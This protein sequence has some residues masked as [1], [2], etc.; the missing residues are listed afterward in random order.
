MLALIFSGVVFLILIVII[1]QRKQYRKIIKAKEYDIVYHIREQNKLAK[2]L[3]YI[4]VEKKVMEKI[5][6]SKIDVLI[7]G[8][9]V[10]DNG[11]RNDSTD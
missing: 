8:E 6:A 9:T 4:N 2:E 10:I 7:M 3:E 1:V 5:L 11:G